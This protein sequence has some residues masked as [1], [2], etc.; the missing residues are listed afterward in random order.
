VVGLGLGL[1]WPAALAVGADQAATPAAVETK[2]SGL[3]G[4]LDALSGLPMPSLAGL[5]KPEKMGLLADNQCK[6]SNNKT[7]L[8][9][10]NEANVDLLAENEIHVLSDIRLL[11]GITIN[12]RITVHDPDG[13]ASKA[14]KSRDPHK[15]R[16]SPKRKASRKANASSPVNWPR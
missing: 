14:K 3:S 4:V 7:H 2:A 15:S 13:R 6:V 16:N 9:S 8:L 12:V 11:S 1:E 5:I 10:D